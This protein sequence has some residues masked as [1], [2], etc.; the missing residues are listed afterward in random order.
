[1]TR[2]DSKGGKVLEKRGKEKKMRQRSFL[3]EE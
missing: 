3:K 2:D 1:V